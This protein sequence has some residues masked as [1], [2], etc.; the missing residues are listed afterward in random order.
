MSVMKSLF[1][2]VFANLYF[3]FNTSIEHYFYQ[4]CILLL[5]FLSIRKANTNQSGFYF[6]VRIKHDFKF[7]KIAGTKHVHVSKECFTTSPNQRSYVT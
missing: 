7:L 5:S 4:F 1:C 3:Y 2:E 6:Q